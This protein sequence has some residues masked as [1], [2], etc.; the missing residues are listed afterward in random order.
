VG[1]ITTPS[2]HSRSRR[3]WRFG[4]LRM[5]F[6]KNGVGKAHVGTFAHGYSRRPGLR[7][8]FPEKVIRDR[9]MGNERVG[10]AVGE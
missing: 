1:G 10:K 2:T 5:L 3:L 8:L 7:D 4:S 9:K 6:I